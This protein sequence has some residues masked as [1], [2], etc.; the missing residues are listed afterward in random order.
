MKNIDYR[1]AVDA[2]V[3]QFSSIYPNY[4]CP[5][6]R[7]RDNAESIKELIDS[8]N[9]LEYLLTLQCKDYEKIFGTKLEVELNN[10]EE[11]FNLLD[12]SFK[13]NIDFFKLKSFTNSR[14]VLNKVMSEIDSHNKLELKYSDDELLSSLFKSGVSSETLDSIAF[15]MSLSKRSS[16]ADWEDFWYNS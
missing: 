4:A 3:S 8:L 6:S 14:T 11:F 10:L 15:S 9:D 1:W 2:Y 16:T 12:K 7:V 13:Y 5:L